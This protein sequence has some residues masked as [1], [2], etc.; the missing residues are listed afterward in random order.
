[1]EKRYSLGFF[2]LSLFI[3]YDPAFAAQIE[4]VT[5][6]DKPLIRKSSPS[7]PARRYPWKTSIVTTVFWIGE[8]PG[9]N[10]LVPNRTSAWDKRW[11]KNYGGFDDPNTAH[12]RKYVPPNYTTP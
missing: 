9:G 3:A 10:K 1:M 8:Q 2:C 6:K 4:A 5:E 12:R 7:R 11:T